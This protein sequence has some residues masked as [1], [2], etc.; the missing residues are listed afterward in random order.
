MTGK[1]GINKYMV[2]RPIAIWSIFAGLLS[3]LSM[4]SLFYFN[5]VGTV[6]GIILTLVILFMAILLIGSSRSIWTAQVGE[7]PGIVRIISINL[8]FRVVLIYFLYG[9]YT[10]NYSDAFKADMAQALLY[11]N[12]ISMAFEATALIVIIRRREYFALPKET[13]EATMKRLK[14]TGVKT[15]SDCPQCKSLVEAD[16]HSCPNCGTFLP[17]FCVNCETPVDENIKQCPKCGTEIR[18]SQAIANLIETLRQTAELPASPETKS[19]RYEKYAEALIK[20]GRT[21]EA[22]EAYKKSIHFTQFYRKQTNFMV[23]MAMVYHN[24][25]RDKQALD[26]LDA[27]ME[28]D[29]EDWAGAKRL[30]DDILGIKGPAQVAITS[31]VKA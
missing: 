12:L 23:K 29:P 24:T 3:M 4:F 28:L 11:L 2:L 19:V 16:W 1:E 13:V 21:D 15:V 22:I 5:S 8:L 18:A 6:L 9:P 27:S 25:G 7:W 10:V 20:G 30:K 17:K 26:L 14:V 31:P